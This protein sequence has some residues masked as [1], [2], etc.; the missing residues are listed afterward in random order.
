V[1]VC[2]ACA[3]GKWPGYVSGLSVALFSRPLH[4]CVVFQDKQGYSNN[5]NYYN[6]PSNIIILVT[7][8]ILITRITQLRLIS[9]LALV[10]HGLGL[11]KGLLSL[12]PYY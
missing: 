11:S 12:F 8:V 10:S 1:S 2:S 9:R 3:H 6:N 7:L 5:P 4:M